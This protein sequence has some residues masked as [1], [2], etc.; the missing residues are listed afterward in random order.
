MPVQKKN[1]EKCSISEFSTKGQSCIHERVQKLTGDRREEDG[2]EECERCRDIRSDVSVSL[3]FIVDSFVFRI[4]RKYLAFF[5][6]VDW[7]IF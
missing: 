3:L 4:L 6:E 5:P 7:N 2:H 1:R